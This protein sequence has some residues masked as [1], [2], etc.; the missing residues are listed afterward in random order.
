[1]YIKMSDAGASRAVTEDERS[2]GEAGQRGITVQTE[3]EITHQV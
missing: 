3:I 2:V 1:M